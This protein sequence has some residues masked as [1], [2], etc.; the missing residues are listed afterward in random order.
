MPGGEPPWCRKAKS[1]VALDVWIQPGAA[2][3]EVAGIHDGRLKLRIAA[4]PTEGR[5]NAEVI[6]FLAT[7]LVVPKSAITINHGRSTR[8]KLVTIEEIDLS[9]VLQ[10]IGSG[11]E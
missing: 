11:T 7:R 1:G 6:R 10:Q 2:R 5:A 8:R 3:S 4:P 9:H